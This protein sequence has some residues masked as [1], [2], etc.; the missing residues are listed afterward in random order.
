MTGSFSSNAMGRWWDE[1]FLHSRCRGGRSACICITFLHF[2]VSVVLYGEGG[3]GGRVRY[4][5][6]RGLGF[7]SC[8]LEHWKS[9]SG[10]VVGGGPM[11][12]ADACH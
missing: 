4:R 5:D 12:H 1:N 3:L 10:H 6:P 11:C 7:R 8:V 9:K 2:R